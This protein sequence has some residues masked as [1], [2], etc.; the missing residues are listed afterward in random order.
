M[1]A[2]WMIASA[3]ALL[4]VTSGVAVAQGN[5]NGQGQNRGQAKKAQRAE[6]QRQA[7]ARIND[8]DR[9]AANTW[10][11][12]H[13]N[14]PPRGFRRTD[15]LPQQ[16]EARLQPGYQFDPYMRRRAYAAPSDLTR[17]FAPAPRGY[18]YVVIGGH[19]VL[20]DTGYRVAD[21]F[22]LNISFGN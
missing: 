19:I 6:D 18:R 5:G 13:R 9:Q 4:A 12:Q 1:R 10:Y 16:Y 11:E 20:V 14:S 21:V 8:H 17:G 2:R 22:R 15:R 7:Q 3:V